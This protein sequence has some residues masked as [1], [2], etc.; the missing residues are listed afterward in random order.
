L[1]FVFTQNQSQYWSREFKA[2]TISGN[3]NTFEKIHEIVDSGHCPVVEVINFE[4]QFLTFPANSLIALLSTDE[5]YDLELN[6]SVLNCKAFKAVIRPYKI[7]ERSISL[8]CKAFWTGLV[9][10]AKHFSS[11]TPRKLVGWGIEGIGMIKRQ[12]RIRQMIVDSG[13]TVINIPLGYTDFFAET[14]LENL[15]IES[16]K[17]YLKDKSLLEIAIASGAFIQDKVYKFVFI[18]QIGQIVR[19]FAI[20]ALEGFSSKKL[21]IRVTYGGVSNDENRKLGIGKE[22]VIGLTESQISVCPPG[23]ISGNS[24]RIMESLICGAFPAVMSNV[25]CDPMFQSPV[26][27]VFDGHKPWTWTR[28]LKKIENSSKL[29]LQE[30]TFANLKIFREEIKVIKLAIEVFQGRD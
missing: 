15:K 16:N 24:Y 22:Y 23:N 30:K 25:L 8:I 4:A 9:E 28:Y 29:D 6:S 19:Q 21:V 10:G 14:F 2:K 1:L 26:L 18:G 17:I 20:S 5:K 11:Q 7:P 3:E 27:E 12:S 13:K